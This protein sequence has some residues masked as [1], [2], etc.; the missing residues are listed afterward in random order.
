MFLSKPDPA[1]EIRPGPVFKIW[2]DPVFGMRTD[3]D[4]TMKGV[5]KI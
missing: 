3:P 4:P 2:S 5:K 1:Y